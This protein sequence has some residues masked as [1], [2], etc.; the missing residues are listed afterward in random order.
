MRSVS[1]LNNTYCTNYKLYLHI[2][3]MKVIY[4]PPNDSII[5]NSAIA[6]NLVYYRV[7]TK[8]NEK[9]L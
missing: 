2:G 1:R 5:D 4:I 7:F 8:L 3:I 6:L 9:Q